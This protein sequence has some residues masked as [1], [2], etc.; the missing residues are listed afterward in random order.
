MVAER[1]VIIN[2]ETNFKNLKKNAFIPNAFTEQEY[3]LL[4]TALTDYT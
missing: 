3:S 2:K 1:Q 4:I